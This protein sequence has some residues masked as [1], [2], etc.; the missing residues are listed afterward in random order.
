MDRRFG[1]VGDGAHRPMMEAIRAHKGGRVCRMLVPREG[2][3]EN[4]LI[5]CL[6]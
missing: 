4:E 3:W 1:R 6:W 2:S 5:K